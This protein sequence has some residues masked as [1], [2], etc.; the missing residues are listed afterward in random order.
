LL[1]TIFPSHLLK[2]SRDFCLLAGALV[3]AQTS[4]TANDLADLLEMNVR[5]IQDICRKLRSVLDGGELVRF[6][7]QSFVDF[8]IKDSIAGDDTLR[9]ISRCPE[10]FRIDQPIAH[11]MFGSVIFP[12][13]EQ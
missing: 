7:H 2:A 6:A 10:R 4:F 3:A 9:D 12:H 1:S 5:R 8:L 13:H 11:N